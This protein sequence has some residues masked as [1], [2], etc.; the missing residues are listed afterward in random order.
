[1]GLCPWDLVG[2]AVERG[3]GELA[4]DCLVAA[5]Q[6]GTGWSVMWPAVGTKVEGGYYGADLER[7][8]RPECLDGLVG[9]LPVGT[10]AERFLVPELVGASFEVTVL[11]EE[12]PPPKPRAAAAAPAPLGPPATGPE[13]VAMATA[14]LG[15]LVSWRDADWG[16]TRESA[17]RPL[18][19]RGY[20]V[21]ADEADEVSLAVP[22]APEAR[23][24]S[25]GGA[26]RSVEFVAAARRDPHL[27]SEDELDAVRT[28]YEGLFAAA[29]VVAAPL[30]GRPAFAGGAGEA[31]FPA[32][33][34]AELAA[35]WPQPAGRILV[36]LRH[37]DRELP[38]ELRLVFAA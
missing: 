9:M 35:V 13:A 30:L 15:L 4:R 28:A 8:A 31:G 37:D 12:A 19:A 17:R 1:M 34:W 18:E 23:V 6:L 25:E 38:V 26:L 27:L 5:H 14:L 16:G 3:A 10:P 32:D 21:V 36:E 33:R 29:V 22:G 7:A 11:A 20:A 2:P 24:R